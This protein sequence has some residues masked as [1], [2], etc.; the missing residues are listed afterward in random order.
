MVYNGITLD[1]NMLGS[2][3][4]EYKGIKSAISSLK[5]KTVGIVTVSDFLDL[6]K[7]SDRKLY[8]KCYN[9]LFKQL[10][11]TENAVLSKDD[12]NEE[13]LEHLQY[14][15]ECDAND[16]KNGIDLSKDNGAR[17]GGAGKNA[18][19]V[20]GII[21][22][23]FGA[24]YGLQTVIHNMACNQYLDSQSNYCDNQTLPDKSTIIGTCDDINKI[25]I[26]NIEMTPLIIDGQVVFH[27]YR[28]LGDN[29][30]TKPES[31][32]FYIEKTP[33]QTNLVEMF[34]DCFKFERDKQGVEFQ[35]E[36]EKSPRKIIKNPISVDIDYKKIH[37]IIEESNITPD[38]S[39]SISMDE[40][41]Y[42]IRSQVILKTSNG[43]SYEL[44]PSKFIPKNQVFEY[45]P[46]D[47]NIYNIEGKPTN[48]QFY[49]C[50]GCKL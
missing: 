7:T 14:M 31:L 45:N 35:N 22:G 33:N 25:G 17:K 29:D 40:S 28:P 12:L 43:K 8:D 1:W 46:E 5:S 26:P 41:N 44:V 16:L 15:A 4:T 13:E 42:F 2:L 3:H 27:I 30:F 38:K 23:I 24:V 34:K 20:G 10:D 39:F 50:K 9:K 48:I 6:T 19:I 32:N 21:V 49:D 36:I 18:L 37:E 47:S 11:G